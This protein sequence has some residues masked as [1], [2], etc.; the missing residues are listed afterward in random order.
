VRVL[1]KDV[2]GDVL[3]EILDRRRRRGHEHHA[4][5]RPQLARRR[6]HHLSVDGDLA[7]FDAAAD[8]RARIGRALLRQPDVQPLA[9]FD[10]D[11]LELFYVF[12]GGWCCERYQILDLTWPLDLIITSTMAR[13]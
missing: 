7:L 4:L 6:A 11:E 3:R 12:D 1:V 10:Y 8:L 13:S 9:S 5:A 2:E